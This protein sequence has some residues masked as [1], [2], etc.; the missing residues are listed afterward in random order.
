M[1]K[2]T[3]LNPLKVITPK[4]RASFPQLFEAK[5]FGEQEAKFSI[6]MLFDKKTDLKPLQDV[7]KKAAQAKWGDQLPKGLTTPFANGDEKE[8][9]GYENTIVVSAAS[10]FKPPVVNQ[11]VE[12]ILDAEEFY[13]GCY[14]RAAL[15]AYAWEYS[16]PTTKKVMKRGVSFNLES[17][18]K[19]AEGKPF[20]SRPKVEDTF[21]AV[22]DGSDDETNYEKADDD[23]SF[24]S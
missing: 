4:F 18:Q 23:M 13:A 5:A 11:K 9:E 7:V 16:D 3:K 24:L 6:K 17:V 12:P 1:A 20:V 14:A 15:V 8:Y 2:E 22:E 19:L 21:D 10:K